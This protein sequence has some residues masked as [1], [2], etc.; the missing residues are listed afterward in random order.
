MLAKKA[1]EQTHVCKFCKTKFHKSTTLSTHMCVK[2][3]R[4]LDINTA[5][6]RFGLRAFQ[7]FYTLTTQSKSLKSID[8]FIDS[9]Y[10]ID[11][12][13]FGN[14]LAQLKPLYIEKYIDFVIMNG[15]KLKDW[16]KDYVYDTYID[17]LIKK[18]PAASWRRV[19]TDSRSLYSD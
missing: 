1:M 12:A 3:R 13:K 16:S 9:P 7:R 4:H 17:D 11:F 2:K 10:Y 18:E 14:H 5:G 8:D 6:S 15:I 19:R